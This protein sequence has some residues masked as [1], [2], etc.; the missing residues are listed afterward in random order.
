M[1]IE[2]SP[3]LPPFPPSVVTAADAPR[4]TELLAVLALTLLP[5]TD[6]AVPP[7]PPIDCSRMA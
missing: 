4:E 2:I 1:P 5:S 7:P 3:L 6:P